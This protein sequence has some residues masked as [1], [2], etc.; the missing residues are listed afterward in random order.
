MTGARP[1]TGEPSWRWRRILVY[2]TVIACFLLIWRLVDSPDTRVNDTI[3]W[4][5]SMIILTLVAWY[6][7]AA[8]IQDIIAIWTMRSARP[9]AD[10]PADPPPASGDDPKR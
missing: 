1:K 4:M 7:G 2:A 5:L 6:T 9:Y 8:T 3:A 10:A